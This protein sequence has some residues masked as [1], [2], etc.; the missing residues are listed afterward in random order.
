MGP[1]DCWSSRMLQ[2]VP[3]TLPP[4][5]VLL[6]PAGAVA[7]LREAR[8]LIRGGLPELRRRANVHRHVGT[9]GA[10]QATRLVRPAHRFVVVHLIE[11]QVGKLTNA[12]L[13]R[14]GWRF[15]RTEAGRNAWK[16]LR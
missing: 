9:I 13:K 8:Q 14:R 7:A 11:H 3:W 10:V 16:P 2:A 15:C 5:R 1:A 4:V 12:Q 6:F